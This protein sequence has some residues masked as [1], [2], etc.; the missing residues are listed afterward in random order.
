MSDHEDGPTIVRLPLLPSPDE[1]AEM[2]ADRRRHETEWEKQRTTAL[3]TIT[4]TAQQLAN[5]GDALD[6]AVAVARATGASW[7]SIGEAAGISRQ[8]ASERWGR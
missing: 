6:R 8:A 4:Q 3:Q 5:V 2:A 1:M 7:S